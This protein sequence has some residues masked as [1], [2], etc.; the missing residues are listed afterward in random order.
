MQ[1]AL[2]LAGRGWAGRVKTVRDGLRHHQTQENRLI[3]KENSVQPSKN[4]HDEARTR[5]HTIRTD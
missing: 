4:L 2:V 5:P 3:V 1:V